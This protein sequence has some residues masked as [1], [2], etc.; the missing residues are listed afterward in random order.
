MSGRSTSKP[1]P[2]PIFR[3]LAS[4]LMALLFL[5]PGARALP[6]NGYKVNFEGHFNGFKVEEFRELS[7]TVK[8][9]GEPVASMNLLRRRAERDVDRFIDLLRSRGYFGGEVVLDLRGA[10]GAPEVCFT[11]LAGPVYKVSRLELLEVDEDSGSKKTFSPDTIASPAIVAGSKV[12]SSDI[13]EAERQFLGHFLEEG[14]PFALV[15]PREVVVDHA[16]R[17]AAV[18]L[19]VMPGPLTPIGETVIEGL[20]DVSPDV[21]LKSLPWKPGDL[22]RHS[23]LEKAR[24]RLQDTGLFTMINIVPEETPEAPGFAMMRVSLTERKHRSIGLGA[25]Y[26]SDDGPGVRAM[27]EH[28]NL[29]GMGHRLR[30]QLEL[31]DLEPNLS[32]QYDNPFFLRDNQTLSLRFKA[33]ILDPEPYESRSLDLSG[34]VERRLR[35]SLSVGGG[36]TLRLS[37]V[38]QRRT[39]DTFFLVSSPWVLMWDMRDDRLDPTE[40][41][42]LTTRQEPHLDV[43]SPDVFFWKSEAGASWYRAI[44]AEKDW[45]FAARLHLGAIAGESLHDIPADVRFYAG[46]GGSVRGYGYQRIGP[47]ERGK[48]VGGRS[49]TDWSLEMRKRLT[50]SLGLAAFVDGGAAFSSTFPDFSEDPRWGAGLGVRYFTPIGPVRLDAAMP[51]NPRHGKDDNVQFYISIGQAF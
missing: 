40:G 36:L 8:F 45:V 26:R 24:R 46:G 13:L 20:R 5:C 16:E 11:V 33:S 27:W 29:F 18:T 14:H 48:V 10:P 12:V 17:S 30:T 39:T 25:D 7:D 23:L 34:M 38:E 50:K 2:R 44:G 31:S 32:V 1:G 21:V 15:L 9:R 47:E 35:E 42:L 4:V 19:L 22:C 49:A 37:R 28:R 6:E 3:D 41:F 51:L 43:T